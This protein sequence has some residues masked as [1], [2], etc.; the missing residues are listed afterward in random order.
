MRHTDIASSTRTAR[1]TGRSIEFC[2]EGEGGSAQ[3]VV[4]SDMLGMPEG[5]SERQGAAQGTSQVSRKWSLR[6]LKGSRSFGSRLARQAAART[7]RGEAGFADRVTRGTG[8]RSPA[9][10]IVQKLVVV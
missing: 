9:K 3:V 5:K 1:T 10:T 2:G 6:T 7:T 4:I 8:P